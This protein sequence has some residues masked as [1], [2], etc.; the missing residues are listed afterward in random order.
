MVKTVNL[1]H[2]F[3]GSN[4]VCQLYKAK[5]KICVFPVTLNFKIRDGR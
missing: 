4:H 5:E 2:Y 3:E 1:K